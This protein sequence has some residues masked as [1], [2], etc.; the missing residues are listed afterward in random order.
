M[1][2]PIAA[3]IGLQW[4]QKAANWVALAG[5]LSIVTYVVAVHGLT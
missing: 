3:R 4:H 1:S 5:A 2:R